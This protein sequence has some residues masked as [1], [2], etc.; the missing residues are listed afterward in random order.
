MG[1]S[2]RAMG[3]VVLG[4]SWLC[5]HE[6]WRLHGSTV[7]FVT[8]LLA[9]VAFLTASAGSAMLIL[10]GYLFAEIEVSRR[11]ARLPVAPNPLREEGSD[12]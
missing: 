7:S 11:W 5:G 8:F 1:I 10:G 2:I 4:L 9:L 6:L 3:L 12:S